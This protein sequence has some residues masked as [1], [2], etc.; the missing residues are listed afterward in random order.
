MGTGAMT[1]EPARL[2]QSQVPD[3]QRV[4]GSWSVGGEEGEKREE[5]GG[6]DNRDNNNMANYL[7]LNVCFGAK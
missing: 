4:G 5:E 2:R 6:M 7:F 3:P 1:T